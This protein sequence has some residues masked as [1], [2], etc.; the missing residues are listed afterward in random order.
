MVHQLVCS[1]HSSAEHDTNATCT[2]FWISNYLKRFHLVFLFLG[3]WAGFSI[4]N[5]QQHMWNI[6]LVSHHVPLQTHPLRPHPFLCRSSS[7]PARTS[8]FLLLPSGPQHSVPEGQGLSSLIIALCNSSFHCSRIFLINWNR[9]H[10]RSCR[11][12]LKHFVQVAM[13]Q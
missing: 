2:K 8:S 9:G 10:Q 1:I 6:I 5:N 13:M 7:L 11:K 4:R 3:P 12:L